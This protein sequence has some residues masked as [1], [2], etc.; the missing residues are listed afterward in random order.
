[1]NYTTLPVRIRPRFMVIWVSL[2]YLGICFLNRCT[3]ARHKKLELPEYCKPLDKVY[4]HCRIMWIT[5][6]P[7]S[8]IELDVTL[9]LMLDE[10]ICVHCAEGRCYNVLRESRVMARRTTNNLNSSE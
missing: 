2:G 1:M 6:K 8:T 5:S 10:N 7:T 9:A 3:E 4:T